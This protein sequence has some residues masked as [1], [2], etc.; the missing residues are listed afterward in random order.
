MAP[1]PWLAD[2]HWRLRNA[3]EV[4]VGKM[5]R[6]SIRHSKALDSTSKVNKLMHINIFYIKAKNL[7]SLCISLKVIPSFQR[8]LM[9]YLLPFPNEMTSRE[10]I[11][12]LETKIKLC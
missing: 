1:K 7:R 9:N 5:M 8:L 4:C 3:D 2:F 10:L 6:D 12:G 11:Q